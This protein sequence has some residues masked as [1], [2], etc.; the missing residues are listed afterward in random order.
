MPVSNAKCG[1]SY[2]KWLEL[3]ASLHYMHE[4]TG[5]GFDESWNGV[6]AWKVDIF[7]EDE[8]RAAWSSLEQHHLVST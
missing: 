4:D 7:D 2:V 5:G 3:L 6:K 8:A 1:M